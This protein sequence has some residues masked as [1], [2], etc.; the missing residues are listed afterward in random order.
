MDLA[1]KPS[2]LSRQSTILVIDDEIQAQRLLRLNLEPLGYRIVIQG[3]CEGAIEAIEIHQPD[4]ILLDLKLSDGNGFDLC[5]R[6]R[7]VSN[8]PIIILSGYSQ[9]SD[10]ARAFSAGADDYL[11][12][13]YDPMELAARIQAILRR[14]ARTPLEGQPPFQSGALVIHFEQRRV[15]VD[16]VEVQLSPTEYRLLEYL[17]LN[18]GRTVVADA[19]LQHVWGHG[20]TDDYALLHKSISR[21]R[22]KIGDD[23]HCPRFIMTKPGIGYLMLADDTTSMPLRERFV[24]R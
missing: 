22:S 9:I 8:V 11:V 12:K 4:L 21:L 23:S 3:R 1:F 19:L 7:D 2:T 17:S 6:I 13:P 24:G 16:G 18:A 14:V 20:Q 5:Y 15:M 10:K